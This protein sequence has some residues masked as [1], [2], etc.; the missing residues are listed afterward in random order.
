[1]DTTLH[2]TN[3]DVA[4]ARIEASGLAGA[5]VLPWRDVLHEGPVPADLSIDELRLLRARFIAERG[6]GAYDAVEK[7]FSE[8][9]ALL[10]RFR[11]YDEVVLWFEGD[12][13]D[14]L[15][16]IQLLD[17]FAAENPDGDRLSLIDS[18]EYL[19]TMSVTDLR[20]LYAE[21]H[22]VDTVHLQLGRA[23][24]N[25]FRSSDPSPIAALIAAGT[26]PLPHLRAALLRHLQEFPSVRNG[27]SRSE[28]QTLEAIGGGRNVLSD[29]FLA[30]HHEREEMIFLGDTVFASYLERLSH[31]S[32]PLVLLTDG[33]PIVPPRGSGNTTGF[34]SRRAILTDTGEQVL[35]GE[36][37]AV[38]L[39]GIDRWLGGT[40]LQGTEARWRWDDSATALR[41]GRS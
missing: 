36:Q 28:A 24:W 41:I 30:S 6:W 15:Q 32:R 19:G 21:R 16:L 25:A 23:A 5:V 11:D 31:G 17:Y 39:R 13:Y 8:R 10:H 35:A 1:M 7:S 22:A 34:W 3:G 4:A 38:A 37:D 9:D 27:L 2:I 40:Y 29:A 12:L 18:D 20:T 14:Q 26:A 33:S